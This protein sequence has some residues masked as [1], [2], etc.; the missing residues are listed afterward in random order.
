MK[1]EN[2]GFSNWIDS[3]LKLATLLWGEE[4]VT[5]FICATGKFTKQDIYDRLFIEI[6]NGV[7]YHVQYWPIFNLTSGELMG[8]CGARPFK[9]EHNSYEIG[10]HIR[11]KFWGKG[12]A[13]ESVKEV[14]NYCFTELNAVKLFA[15]HHPQNESSKKLLMRLGFHYIGDK[16][17]EPTS[18]YHPSYEMSNLMYSESI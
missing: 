8:C 7:N 3:D 5:R 11:K 17:Y 15:G 14:I 4:D 2:I 18:L 9:S 6:N 13:S 1:T 16:F 10:V 12:F